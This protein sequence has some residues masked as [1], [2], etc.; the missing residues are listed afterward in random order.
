MILIVVFDGL[1]PELITES[2]TP[3]L[4]GLAA[5]GV[6]FPNS[7]ATFPT[8]TR[9]NVGSMFT[10]CYPGRHGVVG[11]AMYLPSLDPSWKISTGDHA[12]LKRL[13]SLLHGRFVTATSLGEL[14]HASGQTMAAVGL[15]STGNTFLHHHKAASLR[16]V[17]VHPE[18]TVPESLGPELVA[19]FGEW[20]EAAL[21]ND[22]RIS[23]AVTILLDHVIPT[24]RPAVA[25]LWMSDPDGTQ[26]E[27]GL[28]SP[29]TIEALRRA[30][31]QLGRILDHVEV[32]GMSAETDILILSDHGHSTVTEIVD[33]DTLLVREGVKQDEGSTDVLV[34]ENGGCAFLYVPDHNPDKVRAAVEL[35]MRQAW[36][37]PVFTRAG[38]ESLPGTFPLSLIGN[39]HDYSPDILMS[40]A[41]S[42]GANGAGVKGLARS[43]GHIAVGNGNHGSLSPYD[44]R[45][46]FVAAGPH[47]KQ[48]VVSAVPSGNVDA[49]PTALRILGIAA[50]G[51]IDGRA[52]TE[53][54]EG[55]PE[56]E[57]VFVSTQVH[58]TSAV[59]GEMRYEQELQI[60]RVGDTEY[61]D[62]GR[63]YRS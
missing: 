59:L 27:T 36:C 43:C 21:P 32:E 48:G 53:A 9:V 45:N 16:G 34:A 54:L 4:F 58:R 52:L 55:G 50:P 3:A 44:V 35:L 24:Y 56:P 62:K 13:E 7:H 47:F 46:T 8:L 6:R 1:R 10:G 28:G 37:G 33:I 11:N 49:F 18:F 30:D 31:T 14:V 41:W 20:P 12:D 51:P 57:E 39:E 2:V 29:D 60:S 63:A 42:S 26:H 40:F 22:A 25:T 15:G 17:V 23:R 61:V 5:R 19:R 38:P